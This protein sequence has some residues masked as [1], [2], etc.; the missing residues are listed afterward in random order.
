MGSNQK[1]LEVLYLEGCKTPRN[2]IGRL[3]RSILKPPWTS[4]RTTR[5][6]TFTL[7]E[8]NNQAADP[9]TF[10]Q[11]RA[12]FEP[13]PVPNPQDLAL[14]TPLTKK[15]LRYK[16]WKYHTVAPI[17][18]PP[19]P[20]TPR[21]QRRKG[22]E[23]KLIFERC[24]T[25]EKTPGQYTFCDHES[26]PEEF[27]T[28]VYTDRIKKDFTAANIEDITKRGLPNLIGEI[29][30]E[31]LHPGNLSKLLTINTDKHV[32]QYVYVSS[33]SLFEPS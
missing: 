29:E 8:A 16:R 32:T 31:M 6:V 26:D 3:P 4:T 25:C 1:T 20:G 30:Y 13:Q 22:R 14:V 15:I 10:A 5:H 17:E 2:T 27:D 11:R 9:T 23:D 12:L 18:L 7:H 24:N 33:K 21:P 28:T 19:P